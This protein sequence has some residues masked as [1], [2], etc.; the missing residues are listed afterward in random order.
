MSSEVLGLCKENWRPALRQLALQI[1]SEKLGPCRIR[2]G[3]F[4]NSNGDSLSSPALAAASAPSHSGRLPAPQQ[5]SALSP[6]IAHQLIAWM[7]IRCQYWPCDQQ[8][9][10]VALAGSEHQQG[11]ME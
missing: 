9:G 3:R 6:A 11:M 4:L 7:P 5:L 8:S 10:V 1:C 2:K